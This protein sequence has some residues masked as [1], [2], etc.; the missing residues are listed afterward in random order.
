MPPCGCLGKEP[1]H[2]EYNNLLLKYNKNGPIKLSIPLNTVVFPDT[3]ADIVSIAAII[4][5]TNAHTVK[6]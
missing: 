6:K 5:K 2:I 4:I 3:I 1:A